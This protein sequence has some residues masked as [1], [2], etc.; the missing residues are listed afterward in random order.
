MKKLVIHSVLAVLFLIVFGSTM[1]AD[2]PPPLLPAGQH[3]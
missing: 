3:L 1:S 2:G